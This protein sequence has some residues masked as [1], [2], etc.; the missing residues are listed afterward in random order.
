[1]VE[2]VAGAETEDD[3][4]AT[5]RLASTVMDRE[6]FDESDVVAVEGRRRTVAMIGSP[7]GGEREIARLGERVR[8]N[9]D[10]DTGNP[11]DVS[12]VDD[13]PA[14]I[15]GVRPMRGTEVRGGETA[16]RRRLDGT[17]V[18]TGDVVTVTLL[19]GSLTV[20]FR[21]TETRPDGPVL[22]GEDAAIELR[23]EGDDPVRLS[24][25][26]VSYR[27]VGG[28]GDSREALRDLVELPFEYGDVFDAFGGRPPTGILVYG[29]SGTGKTLLAKAA[30]NEVTAAPVAIACPA[31]FEADRPADRLRTAA[32]EAVER[33]PALFV[34]DDVDAIGGAGDDAGTTER[35]LLVALRSVMDRLADRDVVVLGTVSD[36]DDLDETLRR[37]GRFDREVELEVPD[38][39]G[40]T[41]ILSVLTRRLPL[42]GDVDLGAI[43]SRTHGFVGADLR[44]LVDEAVLAG[45][46]R[47]V[48]TDGRDPDSD[49]DPGLGGLD[50]VTLRQPDFE[51]ARSAV[52]PSAMRE[53]FVEVPDVSYED[54][55]GLEDA[56]RQLARAV[57]LPLQYP[58]L[59]ERIGT[60]P[61]RGLLLYGPPGTGKTLLA[62]AVASATDANFIAVDGPE[63]LDRYVGESERAVR[64]VFRRARQNAPTAVF[65][66]EIDAIAPERGGGSEAQ[67]IERVVSQLLTELDGIEALGDVVVIAATNRPEIVDPA[68]LRPGRFEKIVEVPIPDAEARE[69]VFEVHT[70]EV[71]LEDVDLTALA[72][73]TEG[74]TGSDIEAVVREACLLAIEDYLAATDFAPDDDAELRVTREQ[75]DR[76]LAAVPPSITGDTRE[77]YEGIADRLRE[78]TGRDR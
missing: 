74:Y 75:F 49:P 66:D 44:T 5:V 51:H 57:E 58:E 17:P 30:A 16:L 54:V 15:V 60:T 64:E 55:G 33:E 67:V 25:G 70:R 27:D 65:F 77:F 9:A 37:G 41:D 20:S 76:A 36:P 26:S 35:R 12:A 56:K 21:V 6:G 72:A 53:L 8:R 3:S 40:R 29:P 38:R 23:E 45:V 50:D 22:V 62:R 13:R 78:R 39:D 69:G 14:R 73:E 34:L 43:A 71:P 28:L 1:M 46:R 52:E 48:G 68:L 10:V 47:V 7:H 42:T 24:T 59:F 32:D 31:L 2:L 63:L 18:V 4:G 61:P 19:R 11:V